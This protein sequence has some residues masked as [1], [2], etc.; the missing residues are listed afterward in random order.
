MVKNIELYFFYEMS[1]YRVRFRRIGVLESVKVKR[2][3]SKILRDVRS[4]RFCA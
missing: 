4:L 3:D 2:P 1:L